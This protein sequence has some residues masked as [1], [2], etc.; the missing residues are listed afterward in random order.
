VLPNEFD[1]QWSREIDVAQRLD[2]FS[3]GWKG[4]AIHL[5]SAR[6]SRAVCGASPQTGSR[7]EEG[8]DAA[9]EHSSVRRGAKRRTR[10]ACAP[11]NSRDPLMR[12]KP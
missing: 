7:A 11:R 1:D 6:A 9:V 4:A 2:H 10:G 8:H 5:G 3:N 12:W